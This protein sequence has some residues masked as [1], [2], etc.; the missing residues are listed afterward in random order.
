M[1]LLDAWALARGLEE[2]S[3]LATAL[4][5]AAAMR[6]FHVRLYQALSLLFTP[7][8]QSDGRLMPFI[9][10]RI[11]PPFGKSWPAAHIQAAMVAGTFG[12]GL[13]PLGLEP[14]VPSPNSTAA[15][16]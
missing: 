3:D 16:A 5:R 11:V 12:R 2:A 4:A 8:Y 13:K 10:D 15:N 14:W 7:A 6:R 9:R 1:A